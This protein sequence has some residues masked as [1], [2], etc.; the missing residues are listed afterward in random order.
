MNR[1]KWGIYAFSF[2][3]GSLITGIA[4]AVQPFGLSS[5]ACVSVGL[6]AVLLAGLFALYLRGVRLQPVLGG[7]LGLL[8]GCL[9]GLTFVFISSAAGIAPTPAITFLRLAGPIPARLRR[10]SHR[11]IEIGGAGI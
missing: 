8:A 6:A 7:L 5:L 1:S 11:N 10:P 9:L 2:F 4:V 3:V